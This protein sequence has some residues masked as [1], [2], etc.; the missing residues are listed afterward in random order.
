MGKNA[1]L[2]IASVCSRQRSTRSVL[3]AAE[4]KLQT[5][6]LSTDSVDK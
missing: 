3:M 4:M 2:S 1:W 5:T 6:S